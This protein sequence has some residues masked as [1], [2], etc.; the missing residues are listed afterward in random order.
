VVSDIILFGRLQ[1]LGDAAGLE[2]RGPG[3]GMRNYEV[4][5]PTTRLAA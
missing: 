2:I 3:P 4:R 5:T 1:A